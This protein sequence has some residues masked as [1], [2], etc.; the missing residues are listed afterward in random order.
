VT[1]DWHDERETEPVG[2]VVAVVNQKGGVG[3]TTVTL[4]LA[5]AAMAKGDRVLV[6]DADPQANA[7]WAL[8]IDP[9]TVGKGTSWAIDENRAGCAASALQSSGWSEWVDVLASSPDLQ[10]RETESKRKKVI[11]LRNALE[12]VTDAYELTLIDCSPAVGAL[13]TNALVATHLAL[14]VVEPAALSIR[15]VAGVSDLIDN[16]WAEHNPDLDLAG[17]IMNRVVATSGEMHRQ[18]D[19]LLKLLGASTLWTPEIPQRTVLAEAIAKR[20]PIHHLGARGRET[21][22][23]FDEHYGKLRKLGRKTMAA[24]RTATASTVPA[25]QSSTTFE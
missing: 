24:K 1:L 17:V 18:Q 12:T 6:V 4:G 10:H 15:G 20:C 13:T 5:S 2:A 14:I 7:T 8:G 25:S 22:A 19:S 21:A 3:K 11:R 16:V 9:S 23:I